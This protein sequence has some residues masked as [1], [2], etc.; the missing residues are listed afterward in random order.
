[1]E[2]LRLAVCNATVFQILTLT[3]GMM[4]MLFC[5]YKG[6]EESSQ[7]NSV[8]GDVC[9]WSMKSSDSVRFQYGQIYSFLL[10]LA[11]LYPI[12]GN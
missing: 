7:V 6:Q 11:K 12:D 8:A 2:Y 4:P 5:Y 10:K 1:M 9:S 3:C